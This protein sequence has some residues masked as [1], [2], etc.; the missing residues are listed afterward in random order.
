M[1]EQIK[2]DEIRNKIINS[3]FYSLLFFIPI[4]VIA[5]IIRTTVTGWMISNTVNVILVTIL[6]IAA[7]KRYDIDVKIKSYLFILTLIL[8]GVNIFLQNGLLSFGPI[9]F[10]TAISLSII[11]LDKREKIKIMILVF[12]STLIIG[13]YVVFFNIIPQYN[14]L[15]YMTSPKAWISTIVNISILVGMLYFA[16]NQYNKELIQLLKD[17]DIAEKKLLQQSKNA[18]TGQMVSNIA[19][20]WRQPMNNIGLIV[21]HLEYA[22]HHIK[23]NKQT[24]ESGLD[25][26]LKT[27]EYMTNTIESFRGFSKENS[28]KVFFDIASTFEDCF[29]IIDSR[30]SA[31]QIV[32]TKNLNA[33]GTHLEGDR[34]RFLQI[35]LNIVN[36]S[37]DSLIEV[38]DKEKSIIISTSIKE[39][40]IEIL[41]EDNG[42]GIKEEKLDLIFEP[43]YST[44]H[45][46]LGTGLGLHI[47]KEIVE[48]D[49]NGTIEA[50]NNSYGGASFLIRVPLLDI[51]EE[52]QIENLNN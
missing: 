45:D 50:F 34:N 25:D 6:Y 18:L 52:I 9:Y 32:V 22:N 42:F 11:L 15:E 35:L 49:F 23:N 41:I 24:I 14:V 30:I 39:N 36:N 44:K 21:Q 33:D 4:A 7:L 51:N 2:L 13:S 10:I 8:V 17:R 20:Q 12:I 5:M 48:N 19:H 40:I 37:I 46:L 1:I 28:S 43:F 47:T 26:I 27:I 29:K 38:N 3:I 31:N 16:F